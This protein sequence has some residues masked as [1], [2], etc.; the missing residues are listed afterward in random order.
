MSEPTS[1]VFI[2]PTALVESDQIGA[3][4]RIWAFVHVMKAASI[5]ENC[6]LCD[7]VFVESGAQI[8]NRVTVKNNVMVWDKV[9]VEDE[10]FLGPNVVLTNDVRPRVAF[11]KDSSDFLPTLIK[12]GASLGANA[13]ILCGIT[14]GEQALIGAGAV[15][16]RDIP[17][18]ALVVGNPGR[19]VGWACACGETLPASLTCECGRN[20]RRK[21]VEE[22]GLQLIS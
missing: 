7:H 11:K 4:T 17:A 13:T 15:V 6:N 16:T 5:G 19:Q 10:V 20:Y 14:I 3:G 8:G 18:H 2:H 12:R 9:T 22:G 21:P 1:T